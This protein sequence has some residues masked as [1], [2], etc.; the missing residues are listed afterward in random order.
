MQVVCNK[1]AEFAERLREDITLWGQ[2]IK[3]GGQARVGRCVL[4]PSTRI[5]LF[6]D[7]R[8]HGMLDEL[9]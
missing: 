3:V 5:E 1:P 9:D 2:A 7:L 4:A 8:A 6:T